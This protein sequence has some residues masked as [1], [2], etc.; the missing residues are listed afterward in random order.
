MYHKPVLLKE[1]IDGLNIRPGGT[2]VD[3]TFGG[4]GHSAEIL[5]RLGDGRLIAFDHDPDAASNLPADSRLTFIPQNFRHCYSF[6]RYHKALPA[7]GVLADLGISS[8]QIDVPGRGFSI[9]HQG[10]LDMR[11]DTR[12]E[13]T[14]AAI[15][16]EYD[17]DRLVR[18]FREYGEIGNAIALVALIVSH[19]AHSPFEAT[20]ELLAAAGSLA[21]RGKENQYLAKVF[22]AIRIELNE[23]MDALKEMLSQLPRILAPGGRAVVI[24]YH[25][26]ED[27]LVKDFFRAGN[28]SGVPEKD[29]FGNMMVPLRAL[30]RKPVVPG[31][32]ESAV[33]T[34]AR[35]ARMRIAEKTTAA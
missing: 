14:A 1:S 16:N 12:I 6:L 28:F 8:H 23:E 9:R 5:R 27:R 3:L 20:T 18:M 31:D 19:R 33:N 13:T 15:L 35:S 22:Q 25:S 32:A 30:T 10:P 24:S 34:R 2:Y 11:M 7:D 29:F 4:G 17:E 21:P 26:L